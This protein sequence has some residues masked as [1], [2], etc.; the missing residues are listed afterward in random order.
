IFPHHTGCS[1]PVSPLSGAAG[2]VFEER[3]TDPVF[4]YTVRMLEHLHTLTKNKIIL[5]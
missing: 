4:C 1:W 5:R 2:L 3:S